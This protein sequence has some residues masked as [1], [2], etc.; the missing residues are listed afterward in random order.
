MKPVT[1]RARQEGAALFVSLML[2]LILTVLG[3]SSS[4]VSIM[5]E[6]MAANV[7]DYNIAFQDAEETLREIEGRISDIILN[8]TSGGLGTIPTASDWGLPPHDCTAT[9]PGSIADPGDWDDFADGRWQAAPT[10]GNDYFVLEMR[11]YIPA[12]GGLLAASACRPVSESGA[13]VYYMIVARG[14]GPGGAEAIVQSI[15]FLPF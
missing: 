13:D 9:S 8:G 4:N 1:T 7:T 11:E 2:L 5:Q 6:R 12:G 14:T 3:L 10:T 15:F